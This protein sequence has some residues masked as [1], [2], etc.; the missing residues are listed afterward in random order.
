MASA[1]PPTLHLWPPPFPPISPFPVGLHAWSERIWSELYRK[2]WNLR[3]YGDFLRFMNFYSK[4]HIWVMNPSWRPK[5]ISTRT[6]DIIRYFETREELPEPSVTGETWDRSQ[7]ER[8]SKWN[9]ILIY[10][11]LLGWLLLHAIHKSELGCIFHDQRVGSNPF[12]MAVK[13]GWF[14][15]L[16]GRAGDGW[17]EAVLIPFVIALS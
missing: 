12:Q 3:L 8:V 9:P 4:Y 11:R 7:R 5:S 2:T 10:D 16:Y 1:R 13:I 15:D 14:L 17:L 6:F